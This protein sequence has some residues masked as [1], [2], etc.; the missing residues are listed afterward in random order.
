M[1]FT[2]PLFLLSLSA[3][4]FAQLTEEVTDVSATEVTNEELFTETTVVTTTISEDDDETSTITE[5][6]SSTDSEESD[7]ITST[8]TTGGN[9]TVPS[10]LD[11]TDSENAA[12][13]LNL[14]AG[15]VGGLAFAA[16]VLLI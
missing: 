6:V 13:N 10:V 9:S 2:A 14:A 11:E 15:V 5:V 16:G 3:L 8:E 12:G 1:Q 7:S 4:A